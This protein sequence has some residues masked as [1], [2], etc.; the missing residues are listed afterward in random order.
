ML[1]AGRQREQKL[2]DR[3]AAWLQATCVAA[4]V[5]VLARA[6][7]ED[8]RTRLQRQKE[9]N[10]AECLSLYQWRKNQIKKQE[11]LKDLVAL[12]G[13]SMRCWVRR[14]L[15]VVRT[16]NAELLGQFLRINCDSNKLVRSVHVFYNRMQRIQ[17]IWRSTLA[18]WHAQ[19]GLL[20]HQWSQFEETGRVKPSAAAKTPE[21][22]GGGGGASSLMGHHHGHHR[23][24]SPPGKEGG[25]ASGGGKKGPAGG[26]AGAQ[27][28]GS[29]AAGGRS[30]A[31]RRS[32]VG[33]PPGMGGDLA[34]GAAGG[35]RQHG[36]ALSKRVPADIK[37]FCIREELGRRRA[38]YLADEQRY[39]E[40]IELHRAKEEVEMT[41]VHFLRLMGLPYCME[42]EAPPRPVFKLHI[43]Q[44]EMEALQLRATQ[45][46][47]RSGVAAG[48]H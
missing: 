8:R 9:K 13:E 27:A 19:R 18:V 23:P 44:E 6:L 3:Q 47:K 20:A 29:G 45:L 25:G 15:I 4:R 17:R 35:G 2:A 43:T 12:V 36:L 16:R 46:W 11:K 24:G 1:R 42:L 26:G 40:E 31:R 48:V 21:R 7:R 37:A 5:R 34:L 39:G 22:K 32:M 30:L 41:R 38:S 10:A 28:G 14:K 33:L